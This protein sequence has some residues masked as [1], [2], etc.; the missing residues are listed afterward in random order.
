MGHVR[1][2]STIATTQPVRGVGLLTNEQRRL[3]DALIST[4]LSDTEPGRDITRILTGQ[5]ED[6]FTKV[7]H[8]LDQG[9][10]KLFVDDRSDPGRVGISIRRSEDG[11]PPP[12]GNRRERREARWRAARRR[13]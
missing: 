2:L 10:L 6:P 12:I 4:W 5:G 11:E 13:R 1:R 3:Y 8:M 9:Q 7:A